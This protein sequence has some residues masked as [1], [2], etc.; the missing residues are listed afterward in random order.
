MLYKESKRD[1]LPATLLFQARFLKI[2]AVPC[3][4][5]PCPDVLAATELSGLRLVTCTFVRL[6]NSALDV[7]S[8][9]PDK[10]FSNA[11]GGC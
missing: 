5:A 11:I 7:S 10:D 3:S 6:C 8:E 9:P 4:F 2:I 1:L